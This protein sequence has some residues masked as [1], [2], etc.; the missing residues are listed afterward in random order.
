VSASLSGPLFHGTIEDLAPGTT[1]KPRIKGGEA[2]ATTNMDAAV[3]HTQDRLV[4]GL[5]QGNV[6]KDVSHGKVYEVEPIH[7]GKLE[8]PTIMT[9]TMSGTPDAVASRLGFVVKGQVASVLKHE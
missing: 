7:I 6:R 5:G 9:Q 2:W 3:R 8:D 1:I 4:Y